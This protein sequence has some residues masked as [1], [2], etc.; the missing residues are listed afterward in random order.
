MKLSEAA[1]FKF[2]VHKTI[3]TNLADAIDNFAFEVLVHLAS[4]TGAGAII[5]SASDL[6]NTYQIRNVIEKALD[7]AVAEGQTVDPHISALEA[8]DR[9]LLSFTFEDNSPEGL[10]VIIDDSPTEP[11]WWR[12][13]P[14]RGP[15]LDEINECRTGMGLPTLTPEQPGSI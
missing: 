6:L 13:V 12:R 4:T 11:W 14:L 7:H 9:L 5:W 8:I 15:A 3:D 2:K 1:A 10:T